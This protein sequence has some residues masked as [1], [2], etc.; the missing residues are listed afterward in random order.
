MGKNGK[1]LFLTFLLLFWAFFG[2]LTQNL[3]SLPLCYVP[4]ILRK[5]MEQ[6]LCPWLNWT[7]FQFLAP[8]KQEKTNFAEKNLKIPPG[9]VAFKL[10]VF[11]TN[12]IT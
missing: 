4:Y 2:L 6:I 5:V 10:I 8:K 9:H 1:S 7:I 3:S 12:V 11:P